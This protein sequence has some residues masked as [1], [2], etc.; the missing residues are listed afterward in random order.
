MRANPRESSPTLCRLDLRHAHHRWPQGTLTAKDVMTVLK[1][2]KMEAE[3]P[4]FTRIY[5]IAYEGKEC[6][7]IIEL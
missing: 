1:E 6:G 4:L 5:E 3:F 7:S 2:K